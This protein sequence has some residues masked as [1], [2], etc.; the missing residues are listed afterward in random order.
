VS[1]LKLVLDLQ[2]EYR[3]FEVVHHPSVI[4]VHPDALYAIARL[5]STSVV[6]R[7]RSLVDGQDEDLSEVNVW[8]TR[9]RPYDFLRDVFG[10]HCYIQL[11]T[12][13]DH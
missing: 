7:G 3:P 10:N 11:S 8:G 6:N 1:S 5:L 4:L 13:G 9:C 2:A 12:T